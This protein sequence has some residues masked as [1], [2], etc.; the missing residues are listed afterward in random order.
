M[1]NLDN[2]YVEIV[3]YGEPEVVEKR[4]GPMSQHKADQV[5]SGAGR[6]LD[7]NKYFTRTTVN[8]EVAAAA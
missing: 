8:V 7:H 1:T 2:V 5:E 4:M 3:K 6:N